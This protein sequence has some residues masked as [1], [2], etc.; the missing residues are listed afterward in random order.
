MS[1]ADAERFH[2]GTV[3]QWGAW[4][5]E[6]HQRDEG[7]WLVQWRRGHGPQLPYDEVM[8]E[9]LRFGW[10]DGQAKTL[11]EQR[12]MLWFRR[13][14]PDSHWSALSKDRVERL[15]A[16]GRMEPAGQRVIDEA[17]A[18][19][20]WTILD[21]VEAMIEPDLLRDALDARPEAR[22]QWDAF[23][24]SARKMALKR[25]ALTKREE[26]KARIVAELVEKAA[27]G[28]RP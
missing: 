6:H 22:R 27:R 17:K 8:L 5:A 23:P 21:S 3:A 9:A 25:L 15:L 7:V 24:P 26:T 19:G 1:M 14:R 28:E 12:S 2:A 11:D 4:L 10:I 20:N 16:Q 13:R 18:N